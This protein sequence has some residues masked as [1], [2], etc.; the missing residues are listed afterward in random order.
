MA[1]EAEVE[2]QPEPVP[3][4]SNEEFEPRQDA[5]NSLFAELNAMDVKAKSLAE[6]KENALESPSLAYSEV[7]IATMH[8][9]LNKVKENGEFYPGKGVFLDLG[10]GVGKACLAAALLHPF[11]KVVG[12]EVLDSLS[13]IAASVIPKYQELQLPEGMAK[14]EVQLE[15]ADFVADFE[16]KLEPLASQVSVCLAL[17]TTFGAEQIKAMGNLARKMPENSF[18]VTF[19]QPLPEE[20]IID[21]DRHPKQRRAEAVKRTLAARGVEPV[22]VEIIDDPPENDP[23]GWT[24]VLEEKVQLAWGIATCYIFKK[25]PAAT[26]EEV[27]PPTE[28]A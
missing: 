18:F 8:W 21:M 19:T 27:P 26:A 16:V 28:E 22:G 14:M 2:Q 5:F 23:N 24:Q 9:V 7:D 10:S 1:E 12:L 25:I 15:K 4:L 17:A 11:E 13:T 6:R 20:L 3:L